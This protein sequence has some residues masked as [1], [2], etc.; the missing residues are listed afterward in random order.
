LKGENCERYKGEDEVLYF[1]VVSGLID[2]LL[3]IKNCLLSQKGNG[4]ISK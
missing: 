2:S 3:G 1:H 4:W